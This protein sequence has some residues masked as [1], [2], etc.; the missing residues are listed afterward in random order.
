MSE[1][2]ITTCDLCMPNGPL[3][4][5]GKLL[6]GM[7]TAEAFVAMRDLGWE[8]QEV[9]HVCPTCIKEQAERTAR[10]V[11]EEAVSQ[12]AIPISLEDG[13]ALLDVEEAKLFT[14]EAEEKIRAV[15]KE[16]NLTLSYETWAAQTRGEY[17][18]KRESL[19]KS[20]GQG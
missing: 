4:R 14:P 11:A 9:G 18:T 16:N 2:T 15:I 10:D 20:F 5:E 12:Q 3:I 1:Y 13:L 17:L 6:R 7:V 19:R 8:E